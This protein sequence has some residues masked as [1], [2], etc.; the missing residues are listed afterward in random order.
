MTG[1]PKPLPLPAQSRAV[2]T[3]RGII[4]NGDRLSRAERE[5][6][7]ERLRAVE[8]TLGFLR[9]HEAEFRAMIARK[10]TAKAD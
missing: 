5:L 10:K 7:D 8:R 3:A 4:N 9:Q 6:M 1:A 2:T